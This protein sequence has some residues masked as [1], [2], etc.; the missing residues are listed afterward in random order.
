MFLHIFYPKSQT[1]ATP[2]TLPQLKKKLELRE[3]LKG[4]FKNFRFF[5]ELFHDGVS[6][7]VPNRTLLGMKSPKLNIPNL[8]CNSGN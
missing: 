4:C 3:H 5:V 6:G 2:Q 7:A 1:G 8:Q